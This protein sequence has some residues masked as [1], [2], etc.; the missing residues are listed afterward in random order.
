MKRAQAVSKRLAACY[1]VPEFDE[2]PLGNHKDPLDEL[3]FIILTLKT[4]DANYRRVFE[5]VKMEFPTWNEALEAP[6]VRLRRVIKPAGLSNQ[7]AP[8]IKSILRKLK[9]VHGSLSLDFLKSM[10]DGQVER[11]L[12]D[13]PGV[14]QK[15]SHCVMMYSLDRDAFPV[16]T[17]TARICRRLGLI[18][19]SVSTKRAQKL[20]PPLIPKKVRRS[21]HV[22]LVRHGRAVCTPRNPRCGECC[23]KRLCSTYQ[24]EHD[25]IRSRTAS[26]HQ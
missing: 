18:D 1:G 16:D 11:F 3:M 4:N 23:L 5:S 20:L 9:K 17:H 14:G 13:L 21:L 8:R 10:P 7:K 26:N 22:N 19:L 15:A 6:L 25:Q 2:P 12:D 24:R